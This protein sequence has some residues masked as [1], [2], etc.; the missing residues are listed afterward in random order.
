MPFYV[1]APLPGPFRWSHRIGRRRRGR[2]GRPLYWL[3]VS[4]E[5]VA[6][7]VIGVVWLFAAAAW[8]CWRCLQACR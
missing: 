4:A 7:I 8:L 1:S 6:L 2:F 5:L 3:L